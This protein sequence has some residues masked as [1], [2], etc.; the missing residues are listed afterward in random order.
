MQFNTGTA[1]IQVTA[2][3]DL[4]VQFLFVPSIFRCIFVLYSNLQSLLIWVI[5]FQTLQIL[6]NSID[7]YP[8]FWPPCKWLFHCTSKVCMCMEKCGWGTAVKITN[9]FNTAVQQSAINE[10]SVHWN[11]NSHN[12]S[13]VQFHGG[14]EKRQ[15]FNKKNCSIFL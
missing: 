8:H 3:D 15:F 14:F 1:V 7:L 2:V 11:C 10:S 12:C 4:E 6:H 9:V 5:I 13:F